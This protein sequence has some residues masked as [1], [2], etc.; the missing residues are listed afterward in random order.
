LKGKL[1]GLWEQSLIKS[2]TSVTG[3]QFVGLNPYSCYDTETEK[4]FRQMRKKMTECVAV[5]ENN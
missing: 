2:T 1:W 4:W 5:D 3:Y